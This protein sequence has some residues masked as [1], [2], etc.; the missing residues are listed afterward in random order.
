[1]N[2]PLDDADVAVSQQGYYA[3]AV[4][5]L[6]AYIIDQFVLTALFTAFL[7]G[8]QYV[9]HLVADQSVQLQRGNLWVGLS[10]LLWWFIYFSYPLAMSGKT[11]GM[12]VLGIR[13]VRRDGSPLNGRRAMLRTVSFP[14]GFLTL[15]I[16]FL[17]I[18]FGREHRAI[19]DRIANTAV[20]YA[21]DARAARLRFLAKQNTQNAAI[22]E[23]ER[24]ANNRE[25]TPA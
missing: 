14:L 6:V 19:Y 12:A 21:W 25:S 24:P 1:M 8:L 9:I 3:G 5:R 4:T 7:A 2:T 23:H 20:V 11:L 10:Y 18:I 15:G 22:R 16:G 17:G 13:V